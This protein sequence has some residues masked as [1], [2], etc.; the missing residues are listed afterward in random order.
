MTLLACMHVYMYVYV[1]RYTL[2]FILY[3]KFTLAY[4]KLHGGKNLYPTH[5]PPL[6]HCVMGAQYTN[7]MNASPLAD[8]EPGDLVKCRHL[9]ELL[10]T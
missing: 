9:N 3:V 4:P 8:N 10:W 1:D 5:C 6:S 7:H 2:L